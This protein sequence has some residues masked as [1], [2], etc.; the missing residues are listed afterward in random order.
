VLTNYTTPA[1]MKANGACIL[2]GCAAD[3][4]GNVGYYIVHRMCTQPNTTYNGNGPLGVPNQCATL[5]SQGGGNSGGSMAVGHWDFQG[6]PQI[7]YRVTTLVVGPR[8]TQSVVEAMVALS[9]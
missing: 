7:Y 2:A 8:N 5:Q 3:A 9:N 4:N 6:N 1:W